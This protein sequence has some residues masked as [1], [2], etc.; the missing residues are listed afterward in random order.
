MKSERQESQGLNLCVE[1][2]QKHTE[3]PTEIPTQKAKEVTEPP[4]KIFSL[5]F[6]HTNSFTHLPLYVTSSALEH[7]E[8]DHAV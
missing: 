8:L 3:I 7:V 6:Q 4:M 2:I 1:E 5:N